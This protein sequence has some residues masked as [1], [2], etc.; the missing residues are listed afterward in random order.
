MTRLK[1]N[2]RRLVESTSADFIVDLEPTKGGMPATIGVRVKG[3]QNGHRITVGGLYAML[4]TRA[5]EQKKAEQRK[6][7]GSLLGRNR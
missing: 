7:R 3:K 6:S 2:L 5:I 1:I 4:A